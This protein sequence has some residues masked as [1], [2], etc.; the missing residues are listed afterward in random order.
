MVTGQINILWFKRDLRIQ[1]NAALSAALQ[2]DLPFIA[3]FIF[4]TKLTQQPD[5]SVRHLYFQFQSATEIKF[6][7][8]QYNIPLYI[9]QGNSKDIFELLF[10]TYSVSSV[11]SYQESGTQLSFERD[12]EIKIICNA[13]HTQWIEFQRDGILR[14]IKNRQGWD[15]A[16]FEKMHSQLTEIQLQYSQHSILP[17][18]HTFHFDT[19]VFKE[20]EPTCFQPAGEKNAWLYLNSFANDRGEN[21]HKYISKPLQSRLSCTRLSPYLAW[22]NISIQQVYQFLK[23]HPLYSKNKFAWNAAITRLRW[24]CHFIQKFETQ[25][26]YETEHVN[27]GYNSFAFAFDEE[28]LNAWK[29]GNTGIPMI[30]ANMRCLIQTGW[31]NFRMRAMLVSFLS[32]HLMQD[33]R[34]GAYHLAQ[35]FLDYEPGIHYTQFQMQAGTTGINTLRIYNPVKQSLEHDPEG[36]FIKKWCPELCNLPINL[37]HEPW[38]ITP[39]ESTLYQFELG[40]DYPKPIVDI[41]LSGSKA[42]KMLWSFKKNE[43]V[44]INKAKLITKLTRNNRNR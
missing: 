22:G 33:W 11:F 19:T 38:K 27:S 14:G 39:L 10:K 32:H 15:K 30:D 21:Y 25:C 26:S 23:Q 24:H 1:N 20:F 13:N 2:S 31:I 8:L 40:L 17:F 4:D 18:Q 6:E 42:R 28:K 35:L 37:I 29:H 12:K 36:E 34:N 43:S 9:L 44:K 5:T 41:E 7:L 3:I 16:W